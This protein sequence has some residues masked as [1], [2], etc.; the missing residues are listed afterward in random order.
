M[1]SASEIIDD[2]RAHSNEGVGENRDDYYRKS[3]CASLVERR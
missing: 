1:F 3:D 2:E